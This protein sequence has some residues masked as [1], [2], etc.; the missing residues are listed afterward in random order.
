MYRVLTP[1]V[2]LWHL[3]IWGVPLLLVLWWAMAVKHYLKMP[4]AWSVAAAMVTIGVLIGPALAL[5]VWSIVIILT[6]SP[7]V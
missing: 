6:G 2:E 4:H 7:V 5:V 3:T 1:F